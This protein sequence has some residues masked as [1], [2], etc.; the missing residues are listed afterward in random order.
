MIK[1]DVEKNKFNLNN[2]DDV[3]EAIERK[4][5]PEK[6]DDL[7]IIHPLLNHKKPSPGNAILT[8]KDCNEV[9]YF[10]KNELKQ[11]EEDPTVY[12]KDIQCENCGAQDGYD[13]VGDVS[14]K[15][16]ES[17]KE[18]EQERKDIEQDDFVDE[19]SKEQPKEP[20]LEPV[21]DLEEPDEIVEESFDKLANKY[22]NKI[23]ENISS[24]K[25]VGISQ[26]DRNK[27]L[28]EGI[29][30][31]KDRKEEKVSFLLETLKRNKDKVVLQGSLKE[32]IE[33]KAPFRFCGRIADNKLLFESM[34]YRYVENIDKDK[35]LVEGLEINK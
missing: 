10:D 22:F 25:T 3:K 11:D 31:N 18:A 1:E 32:L 27:Y 4:D 20:E 30:T 33:N 24:Y 14:L 26:E 17:A 9:F 28:I 8:C 19:E 7:V 34:R 29:L 13:Y 2:P 21:D 16:T 35:Y 5:N 15:D 12:N 6:E 23:Y